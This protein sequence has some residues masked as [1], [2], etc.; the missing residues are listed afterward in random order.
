MQQQL[1]HVRKTLRSTAYE[2]IN[3]KQYYP[4]GCGFIRGLFYLLPSMNYRRLRF[5]GDIRP[6]VSEIIRSDKHLLLSQ[7][8]PS[9]CKV[10]PLPKEAESSL[11]IGLYTSATTGPPK[12]IWNS[13]NRLIKNAQITAREFEISEGDSLLMMAKPWH[14]AGLSWTLMAE[15]LNLDYT[16]IST[17]RGED[18]QWVKAI[19]N[20]QPDYLLTVPAVLRSLFGYEDWFVPNI[21]YGGTPIRDEDYKSL[22]NYADTLYQ[23]YGQTE[24]GGLISC[25]RLSTAASIPEGASR[26]YGDPPKEFKIRCEGTPDNPQP[27]W[28]KSPTATQ[29]G[30]YD[31]G[32]EGFISDGGQLYLQ[33]RRPK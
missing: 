29:R 22:S 30:F 3:N 19:K 20:I 27:I 16:F 7:H 15:N 33:G 12:C 13:Y 5:N 18:K 25:Q 17:K 26:C 2:K 21:V 32:D 31:T 10:A 8:E 24:A 6:W 11:Q 23:G 28:F 4:N 1:I 14:V 9:A